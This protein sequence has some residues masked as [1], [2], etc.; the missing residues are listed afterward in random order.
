[1]AAA[2]HVVPLVIQRLK[3]CLRAVGI[4]EP[5]PV[6]PVAHATAGKGKVAAGEEFAFIIVL[7]AYAHVAIHGFGDVGHVLKGG[8]FRT[9]IYI[10][11]RQHLSALGSEI[12]EAEVGGRVHAIGTIVCAGKREANLRHCSQTAEVNI[13]PVIDDVCLGRVAQVGQVVLLRACHLVVGI[14]AGD[15]QFEPITLIEL[16]GKAVAAR[17][18]VVGITA[19]GDI[20][21]GDDCGVGKQSDIAGSIELG[22]ECHAISL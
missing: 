17:H 15:G 3:F 2:H 5:I 19:V 16:L 13:S 22:G 12:V 18:G 6:I 20:E 10:L 7:R 8:N 11:L 14:I 21:T 9:E 4:A 1:M